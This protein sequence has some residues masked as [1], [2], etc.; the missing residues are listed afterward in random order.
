MNWNATRSGCG[1][2]SP[3]RWFHSVVG[4]AA[5]LGGSG[6][7]ATL[8]WGKASFPSPAGQFHHH[9]PLWLG[10]S[11]RTLKLSFEIVILATIEWLY[12]RTTLSH[13]PEIASQKQHKTL[14]FRSPRMRGRRSNWKGTNVWRFGVTSGRSGLS[15]LRRWVTIDTACVSPLCLPGR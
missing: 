12:S 14:L 4:Q 5:A 6:D 8:G 9:F 13:A 10:S 3:L 11:I 2:T 15:Y 7:T 1:R